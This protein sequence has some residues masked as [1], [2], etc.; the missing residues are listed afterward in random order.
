MTELP[1]ILVAPNGARRDKSAHP[2]LPMSIDELVETCLAC[3]AV[4]AGGVHAH[5]RDDEGLHSLDA[6]RYAEVIERLTEA[7]PGWFVQITSETAGRFSAADQRDLIRAMR[8]KSVSVAVREFLPDTETLPA[9]RETYHWA[10]DNG[11]SIQ[12]ICYAQDELKRLVGLV[13]EGIV[14][15]TSHQV[16]LVLGSYDGSK[17]SR[18]EDI[19]PFIEPMMD[20]AGRHSFDWMLCA[21]GREETDCLLRALELG[22]KARIGFE[23]SLWNKDGTLAKNNAERVAELAGLAG[24]AGLI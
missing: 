21:F 13:E 18:P 14:P 22:G 12:H 15:G 4:G 10:H 2:A 23:N 6:G 20:L 1:K 7:L 3:A 24:K 5:V 9:A 17:V 19:E 11:V 8:P 16:Q